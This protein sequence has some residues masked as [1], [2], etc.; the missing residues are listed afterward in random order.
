MRHSAR[1]LVIRLALSS[2]VGFKTLK[3]LVVVKGPECFHR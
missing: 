1:E 3:L 2:R